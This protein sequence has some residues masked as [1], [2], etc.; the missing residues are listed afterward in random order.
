MIFFAANDGT[1][2]KSL[3]SPVYQGS[4]NANTIYLVAPFASNMSVTVRFQLPN[5]VWTTPYLMQNGHS[6]NAMT[7]QG[8]LASPD[9]AIVDKDT[10]KPYA[11]WT[12]A[13]PS[14]IT[15]YYGTVTVQ[16]FFY[17]AQAGV[18]TA[19]SATSFTVG[20]GVPTVLD[21]I[22][23]PDVYDAILENISALQEQLNNGKFAARSIYAWNDTYIYDAN[24]IVYYP[25]RGDFGVFL[26]SL[27]SDNNAVPYI[28]GKRSE[29]WEEIVDF[30][31][32]NDLYDLSEKM[33]ASVKCAQEAEE[34]AR[35]SENNASLSE[36][37]AL[38]S[39]NSALQAESKAT[40]SAIAAGKS[41]QNIKEAEEYLKGIKTGD[42]AVPKAVADSDGNSIS[43][44]FENVNSELQNLREEQQN[45]SHFRGYV[46]TNAEVQALNGTPNDYAYSAESG[47]VWIYH[48]VTGWGNSE[49]PVPDQT[50]PPSSQTPLMNGT[51]SVGT[52]TS[53][54]RGDHRHPSDTS[55]ANLSGAYFT[56]NICAPLVTGTSGVYD[57]IQRVYSPSNPPPTGAS[58]YSGTPLM[59]GIGDMGTVNNYAR[60]DHRH[61]SDTSKAN[62]SGSYPNMHV[63]VA[64]KAGVIT[65]TYIDGVKFDGSM[66]IFHYN[67]CS[68]GSATANKIVTINQF[69]LSIG[70][71]ISVRFS[72]KNEEDN[73]YLNV[74]NTGAYPIIVVNDTKH[75]KWIAGSL[76]EFVYD[77]THWVCVS[78]Y[79]L[80]DK[81]V[82]SLYMS[83]N[84]K[85]PAELFGGAWT[86]VSNGYYL[87]AVSG[88]AG[89]YNSAGIPNIEGN[90]YIRNSTA[91]TGLGTQSSADGAFSLAQLDSS[92]HKTFGDS[93]SSYQVKYVHFNAN[94]GSSTKGIYGNSNTVTPLNYGVYM[95]IRTA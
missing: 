55:K 51:A 62:T 7:P 23:A 73:P 28:E 44:Q 77:G 14:E 87:K 6:K 41:E 72:Q 18:V 71:R 58:P 49:K 27:K 38:D 60:G 69:Q 92:N 65:G 83:T 57:G 85:S 90:L 25:Y 52:S 2:I 12:Y 42:V 33:D 76:M 45:E 48:A 88:N 39:M 95:W 61:P 78:G 30:N 74:S 89:T 40:Q 80:L 70:A 64:D 59:D 93:N 56:G 17:A 22:E 29:L 8:A 26:K 24:E 5:G 4:S 79:A 50:V 86:S 19:S 94:S 75:I 66:N 67:L 1:I 53:Y 11:V 47:T 43:V 91:S 46:S 81:P 16:F 20:R 3:P 82:G 35:I 34:S 84:S 21:G 63:G 37:N 10:G 54:A 15:A 36:K 31:I 32:L 9:G 68:T 13:L